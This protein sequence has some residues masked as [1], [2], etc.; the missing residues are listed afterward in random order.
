MIPIYEAKHQ[1]IYSNVKSKFCSK[2][3]LRSPKARLPIRD[4]ATKIIMYVNVEGFR[5]FS[6]DR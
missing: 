6:L 3:K 2:L 5:R 1:S 4:D